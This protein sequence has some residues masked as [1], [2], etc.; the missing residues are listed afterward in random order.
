MSYFGILIKELAPDRVSQNVASALSTTLR[1][2]LIMKHIFSV[3]R[4]ISKCHGSFQEEVLSFV[5]VVYIS[6]SLSGKKTYANS[7][8]MVLYFRF[9]SFFSPLSI[10]L[11]QMRD[12][13]RNTW[14]GKRTTTTICSETRLLSQILQKTN[15]IL[16]NI[17]V[18]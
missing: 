14:E 12:M 3:R 18:I 4:S 1:W 6:F 17:I 16:F 8:I 15:W 11:S 10:N 13:E 9:S 2:Y 5:S 7:S